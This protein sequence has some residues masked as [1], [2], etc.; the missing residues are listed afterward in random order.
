MVLSDLL[1]HRSAI[2]ADAVLYDDLFRSG[3]ILIV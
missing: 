3:V 1:G 2:L